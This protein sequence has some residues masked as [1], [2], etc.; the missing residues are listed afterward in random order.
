MIKIQL[1]EL[2]DFQDFLEENI[3]RNDYKYKY[4]VNALDYIFIYK[5]IP[6]SPSSFIIKNNHNWVL[7]IETPGNL[8]IYENEADE[9]LRHNIIEEINLRTHKQKE[10][11]GS[12][13]LTYYLIEN[14]DI[15]YD[16]IK[17]R[18]FYKT[19]ELILI[20]DSHEYDFAIQK[21]LDQL[22]T[23]FQDYYADEYDGK[24][25]KTEE[26]LE[27]GVSN[28]IFKNEILVKR[29]DNQIVAF[30]SMNNPDIGIMFTKNDYRGNGYAKQLLLQASITLLETN[31]EIYVMTDL[32]N[33]PS[34][35]ICNDIGFVEIYRH[36]NLLL[37]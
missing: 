34:N 8:F 18:I 21:D 17:D 10:I 9:I 15:K 29:V 1:Q 11:M 4:L 35:K 3:N 32:H 23:L 6:I 12:N 26:Q 33:I 30:C 14:Q 22:I 27:E 13:D 37:L 31:D 36:T 16:L 5:K 28:Q 25:N 24:R 7:F 20:C 2:D 19:S